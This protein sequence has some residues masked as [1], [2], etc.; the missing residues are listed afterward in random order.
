M[1]EE[2]VLYGIGSRYVFDVVESLRRLG[3]RMRGAVH[4]QPLPPAAPPLEPTVPH[5]A[6]PRDWLP[7]PVILPLLT[8]GFRWRI[9]T[10]ARGLGFSRFA[11][12][13]DPTSV[14]AASFT[15]GEAALVNAACVTGANGRTGRFCV[16]NRGAS[17]GHDL[18]AEDFVTFGP[19]CVVSGSCTVRR[20]AFLGSGAIL[21]PGVTVG[22]NAVVG[23]GAVVTTDVPDRAVVAGN[24]A[25]VIRIADS[26]YNGASVP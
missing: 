5:T 4:N 23:A 11:S 14:I 10:E 16:L 17:L 2:C 20:G 18:V 7:L 8:P 19:S 21:V 13:I 9:E 1:S 15:F 12:L 25:R 3:W 26:G 22:A 24:P 6:I